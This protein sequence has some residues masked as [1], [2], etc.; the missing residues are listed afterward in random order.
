MTSD[1]IEREASDWFARLRGPDGEAERE[2]FERWRD[3]DP[4]HAEAYAHYEKLWSA[5]GAVRR[6][7]ETPRAPRAQLHWPALAA[8]SIAVVLAVTIGVWRFG[9]APPVPAGPPLVAF[10]ASAAKALRL[11]D[12]S[13]VLLAPGATVSVAYSASSR[14]VRLTGGEARFVVAHDAARPFRVLA[15]NCSVLATGTV[16]D[17][18]LTGGDADVALIEGR[19]EVRTAEGRAV[20]LA[21][22]EGVGSDGARRAAAIPQRTMPARISVEAMPLRE[23]LAL[24]NRGK[25]VPI[26]LADPA[27]GERL[28]TGTFDLAD[29]RALARK[30]AAALDLPLDE[31]GGRLVLAGPR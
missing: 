2:A 1:R 28:V 17:V 26:E 9:G 15:G 30:L 11:E 22:G 23:V 7:R 31:G 18:R 27:L 12:G 25:P 6:P 8:A 5:M 29:A 20:Q 19:V 13:V 16:F 24:A 4:R 14:E 3:A 21:P 10:E